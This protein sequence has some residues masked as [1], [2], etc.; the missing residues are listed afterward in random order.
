[1][2]DYREP[3]VFDV[4]TKPTYFITGTDT[5][6]GKTVL[7]ALLAAFFRHRGL[8]VAALKPVCSGGR[9]DARMLQ[10]AL[11]G[12]LTLDDINPWYFRSS[13]APLLA[14]RQEKKRVTLA[15]VL[16]HSRDIRKRF[17]V[18]LTEGAGGLLSPLGVGFNSRDVIAAT[19]ATPVIVAP[20]KLGVI[21]HLLLTL[22]ALPPNLRPA[23]ILV[24]MTPLTPDCATASNAGLLKKLTDQKIHVL[25][26]LGGNFSLVAAL[27]QP[28]VRRTLVAI[29]DGSASSR[30]M[31]AGVAA[32]RGLPSRGFAAKNPA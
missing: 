1:M 20:N 32:A 24:L 3:I 27:K 18:V 23:A 9:D 25:P 22:E 30:R 28:V 8:R 16:A 10:T 2:A 7:T 4:G 11:A 14:A 6:V 12:T 31:S 15:A 5:G 19:G 17:D 29:A 13:L 26:W 21:N